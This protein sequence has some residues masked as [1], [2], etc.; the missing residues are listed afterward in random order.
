MKQE[1]WHQAKESTIYWETHDEKILTSHQ[2]IY[3]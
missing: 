2:F 3:E 1:L